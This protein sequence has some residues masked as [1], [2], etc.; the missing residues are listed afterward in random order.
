MNTKTNHYGDWIKGEGADICLYRDMETN[1][2]V[3]C[4]LP[5]YQKNLI[6]SRSKEDEYETLFSDIHDPSQEVELPITVNEIV[7]AE[8]PPIE[9]IWAKCGDLVAVRPC[10]EKFGDKTYIGIYLGEFPLSFSYSYENG[11]L[12]IAHSMHNPAIFIPE[13]KEIVYGCESWWGKI[14][15]ENQRSEEH[16][17]EL[18]SH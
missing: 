9:S 4:H 1:K 2:V 3:G 17:S 5:L 15:D 6:V 13:M 8:E 10:D 11:R 18:Q 16:T 12:K 7:A 14:K